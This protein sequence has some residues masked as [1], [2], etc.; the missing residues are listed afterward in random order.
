MRLYELKPAKGA[1]HKK[2][3]VGRGPAS[4]HG[5]TSTRGNNGQNSRAGG[6]TRLG[7]EGGQM[8]LIRRVPKRGFNSK[9]KKE[10]II[11]NIE[12]LEKKFN[13]NDI[14]TKLA[15]MKKGII[16]GKLPVKILGNG[17]ISKRLNVKAGSFSE[18]ARKKITEAKGTAELA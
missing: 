11:V 6:G 17:T 14:V 7:F 16:N 5:G 15:L 8:P 18:S 10:Y 12:T 13:D 9:A 4:G 2:K 3:I 1:R